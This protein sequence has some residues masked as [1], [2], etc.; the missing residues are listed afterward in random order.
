MK[1]K[2]NARKYTHLLKYKS[3]VDWLEGLQ[4]WTKYGYLR[5]FSNFL[6]FVGKSPDKVID[7]RKADLDLKDEEAKRRYERLLVDFFRKRTEETSAGS[8]R[9]AVA[10]VRS[11]F[12]FHYVGIQFQRR[13]TR[14]I[15]RE[16]EPVYKDYAPTRED[17][18]AM[19][20]VT[21]ARGRA[22]VLTL[23][24]TGISGD[25]C[26][27]KRAPFEEKWG[28]EDTICL[29]PK[30]GFLYRQK[31][32]VRMRPFLTRD[33]AQAIK[34]Y[35]KTRRDNSE[36]LFVGK[37]AEQLTPE[38]VNLIFQRLAKRAAL[39]VPEG[40]RIRM[41]STRKFFKDACDYV[42][43]S[44]DWIKVL[45]GHGIPGSGDFY[46]IATEER[47]REKFK[48]TEPHLSISRLS[49]MVLLRKQHEVALDDHERMD[50]EGMKRLVG[51]EK[52]RRWAEYELAMQPMIKWNPETEYEPAIY[53]RQR[54]LGEML[55][56]KRTTKKR[57]VKRK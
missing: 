9:T 16:I 34:I 4:E 52:F 20:E 35:L 7:E 8:A 47:L 44:P 11:F 14:E 2:V 5:E 10:S 41:H 40:Y 53:R 57:A 15:G 32:R 56:D 50:F 54:I 49:N 38:A 39:C 1:N 6:K 25:I 29:A 33:A 23:I 24:S 43:I 3:V 17:F 27:L 37:K 13:A 18:K 31:T 51:E 36:W 55:G 48:K 19:C 12:D 45:Y 30:G 26:Y 21:D 28:K 22:I 42:D 46:T